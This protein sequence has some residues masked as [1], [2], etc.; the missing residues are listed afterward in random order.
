MSKNSTLFKWAFSSLLLYGF[1]IIQAVACNTTPVGCSGYKTYQQCD[2]GATCGTA[3]TLLQNNFSSVFPNGVEIGCTNKL[4]FTSATAVKNYLPQSGTSA[5]LASG[6]RTNQ[7][8]GGGTFGG[9]LLAL[10]IN[11]KMDQAL[12]GFASASGNLKDLIITSGNFKN[13]TVQQFFEEANKKIGG[14]SAL[15]FTFSQYSDVAASINKNYANGTVNKGYLNCPPIVASGVVTN[16][17][18]KCGNNGA[19]TLTVTGGFPPYTFKWGNGST[20]QNR[21]NLT[22]GSYSVTVKDKIGQS[23]SLNFTVT[24]PSSAVSASAVA[25]NVTT[26]GGS[27]GKVT[28]SVSGGT[29]P[30]TYVWNNGATTKDLTNVPAGMYKVTVT[31]AKGCKTTA[32]ATVCQPNPPVCN[33]SASAV[34]SDVKCSG[35][36]T[37]SVTLTVN[38]GTAPFTYTWSNGATS[39]D[40][41]NVPAGIYSVIVKDKKNCTATAS[42]TVGQPDPL[43]VTATSTDA[44]CNG[45]AS[46]SVSLTVTGGTANYTYLWNDGSTSKD[47]TGLAD[48]TYSVTVTDA[49]GCTKSETAVVGEPDPIVVT[50]GDV[51]DVLCYGETT[52]SISIYSVTG[53][54]GDYTY[55]WSN[56][57]TGQDLTDVG[58]GMY[59]VVVTD[60]KGC[61]KSATAVV[62]GPNAP[63]GCSTTKTDVKCYGE[64]NGSVDLTVTGGTSPYTFSWS[65]GSTD[66]DLAGVPAGVYN[67][68]IT[69]KNGCTKNCSATVGGPDAGL[70]AS[71]VHVEDAKCYGSSTGSVDLA[72]SGGTAPY[73]Y[74]WS[75]GSTGEDLSGVPAGKYDVTVTDANGCT[76][77]TLATVGEADELMLSGSKENS[78]ACVCNGNAKVTATGGTGPYTYTWSTG[79]T[80]TNELTGLCAM[81]S[82]TVTVTDANGCSKSYDFGPVTQKEGCSA[83]EV[84]SASQGLRQDFTPVDANRSNPNSMKGAP[85]N[86]DILGTFYALGFGGSAVLR[87][88]GA[89]VDKPG[90]DLK[91]VETTWHTWNCDRYTE[92]ALLEVSQDNVTWYSKGI[93][94]QDS[95]IDISPLPCI[96]YV[97]ITD[98]S[99]RADFVTEVPLADGFDVDG[100]ICLQPAVNGRMAVGANPA[101]TPDEMKPSALASASV[102]KS[103]KLYPNPTDGLVSLNMNGITEGQAVDVLIMDHTGRLV[104]TVNFSA[105]ASSHNQEI[106]ID[107]LKTGLYVVKVVG[108]GINYTQKIVKK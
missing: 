101:T 6:V 60:S 19:I 106:R 76:T 61:T 11:M 31:D 90:N 58:A 1:A 30:Y 56:G 91:V 95:E 43:D 52:G 17:S 8:S 83:V 65:N 55:L 63:L 29:S 7:T 97:R 54:N 81:S 79:A 72:V 103:F 77:T 68:T 38:G 3:P 24:Q 13:M 48:G 21:T 35:G 20:S 25:T 96:S 93:I 105:A 71:I 66:E 2:W 94:C 27:N 26:Y 15:N 80:G 34:K 86:T 104:K 10:A 14:C 12:S 99:D 46:G 33:I 85:E 42:A 57:S 51:T 5:A 102:K 74:A 49:K 23:V 41:T 84:V 45:E 40:L 28:L 82:L 108:E 98:M 75:N 100:I 59:S 22:A 36:S 92:R 4:K 53:G 32:C 18:C 107:D 87:V 9:E 50:F 44:K 89:I 37:G 70:S 16:V 67:V 62:E 73:T 47:R 64:S 39:K 69:D 88:D 78:S